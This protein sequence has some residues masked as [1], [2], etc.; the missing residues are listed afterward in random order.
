MVLEQ[1]IGRFASIRPQFMKG[2][3]EQLRTGYVLV[4]QEVIL[5]NLTQF[6]L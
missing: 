2:Y 5:F 1:T 4:V 3:A 6:S